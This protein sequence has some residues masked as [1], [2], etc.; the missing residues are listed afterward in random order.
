MPLD[1]WVQTSSETV[2]KSKI[3]S[4][5]KKKRYSPLSKK[6]GDFEVLR[7]HP[8]VN[9]IALTEKNEVILVEQYRHG[10]DEV[11]L[12]VPGGVAHP[13]QESLLDSAKRELLEETGYESHNWEQ[14]GAVQ[15]NPAFMTNSCSVFFAQG[16]VK[17]QEQNLD[18]LEEIEVH[19]LPFP[20]VIKKV[21]E[22][23]MGH[24]LVVA[25]FGLL[26]LKYPEFNRL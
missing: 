13:D 12:E 14:I 1:K 22:G 20:E 8:W 5:E 21:R 9:M 7:I 6:E 15:A 23:E 3:F 19:C 25:A 2:M 10:V 26:L 18:P 17:T 16:A 11:T 4:Y 24:S